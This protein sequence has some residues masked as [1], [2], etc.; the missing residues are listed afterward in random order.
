M[1]AYKA[2]SHTVCD[3][4]Y[5]LVWITKYLYPLLL[6]DVGQ[7]ARE[8]LREI[9]KSLELIIYAGRSTWIMFTCWF[10]VCVE[11]ESWAP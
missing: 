2:G 8:L 5:H 3:C 4:K 9:S 7:R 6:R 1:K 11:I 10:F